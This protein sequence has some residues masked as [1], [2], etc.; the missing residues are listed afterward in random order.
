MDDFVPYKNE[1]KTQEEISAEAIFETLQQFGIGKALDVLCK[2][3]GVT[4]VAA[5]SAKTG[6]TIKSFSSIEKD[7]QFLQLIFECF[8]NIERAYLRAIEKDYENVLN[9]ES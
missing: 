8:P 6:L 1:H 9:E 3:E 5:L 7:W 4:S 2:H